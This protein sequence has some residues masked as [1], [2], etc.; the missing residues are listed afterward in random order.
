MYIRTRKIIPAII[1]ILVLCGAFSCRP[2]RNVAGTYRSKFAVYGFFRT[3]IRLKP[4]STLEY[5]FRGDLMYDSTTGHY[6]VIGNK[7]YINL[8]QQPTDSYHLHYRFDD[9]PLKRFVHSEDTIRYKVLCY[10]GHKKLFPAHTETGKKV[11]KAKGYSKRKKYLVFGS[12]FYE[13]RYF[14]ERR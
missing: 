14:Y 3:T 2:A 5:V 1:F 6:K 13:R 4:D 11:T 7:V 10:I 12:H 9:L 8:D